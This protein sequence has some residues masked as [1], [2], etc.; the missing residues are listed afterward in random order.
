MILANQG[1][2]AL[3]RARLFSSLKAAHSNLETQVEKRTADLAQSNEQL[4][5]ALQEREILI[6]EIHHRV[7]NNLQVISSMFNLQQTHVDSEDIRQVLREGDNRL[8]AMALIHESLYL[9]VNLKNIDLA[10]YLAFLAKDIFNSYEASTRHIELNLQIDSLLL[11][12]NPAVS[13]GMIVNELI[14]NAL[15]HAFPEQHQGLVELVLQREDAEIILLVRDDG[16]GISKDFE[17][18]VK[19]SM[20]MQVVNVLVKQL[21]GTLRLESSG[22]AMI[23][24]R[25]PTSSILGEG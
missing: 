24:M 14:S 3:E 5:K 22:G 17:R 12:A 9:S 23:E 21:K 16:I 8:H 25:F 6:K 7:K 11:E 18:D 13:L 1:A 4:K 15:K 2:I 20:G 19:K 10:D